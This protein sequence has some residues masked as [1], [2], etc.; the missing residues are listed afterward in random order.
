MKISIIIKLF[1]AVLAVCNAVM[2][3]QAIAMRIS[4]QKG[5]FGYLNDQGRQSIEEVLPRVAAFYRRHGGWDGLHDN[6]RLWIETVR[7]PPPKD[8]NIRLSTAD[9]TGAGIRMGLLDEHYARIV[10]NPMV[11]ARSI[12]QPVVV[13]GKTVGWVAM[14]PFEQALAPGEARFLSEQLRMLWIIAAASVVVVAL[15]TYLITRTGLRR[16]HNLA[17]AAHAL[18]AGD[19]AL[20][21]E[22]GPR[23]EL[24]ALAQDFN[25][26][27]QAL[28]H[29]ERARR[30]FMANISHELRTPLAV[31][32]AEVEAIQDGINPPTAESLGVIHQ[33]V[34]QLG[35]L[36]GDLHDLSLTDIGGQAYQRV[37]ID[38]GMVLNT[39]VASMQRRFEGAGLRLHASIQEGPLLALGDESRLQQLFTNLLENSLRYTDAGGEVRIRCAR[40]A[41][42]IQIHIEDGPPG[43][44]QEKVEHLF[45]RFYRVEESRNRASG[46]SGLGLAI[47]RNIVQAHDGSI[48]AAPSPLGGLHIFIE[49]P[50]LP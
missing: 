4:V 45:E 31:I 47:C 35:K 19:Y 16:V 12:R 41:T 22:A 23:D 20:R 24:G 9:Q 27:A 15:F 32:R 33:E 29:N 1:L 43:V 18:A 28:E 13:D 49:L 14:V 50:P 44:A 37:P 34:G 39:T 38:L 25:H 30:T 40:R 17:Q 3:M 10:G 5:F 2:L 36:I 7:P 48:R 8:T 11:D 6:I 46:G 26:M 21:I 42:A